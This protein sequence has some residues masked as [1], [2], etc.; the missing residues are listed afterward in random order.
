M[1]PRCTYWSL[2]PNL[3]LKRTYPG[4][5]AARQT[6]VQAARAMMNKRRRPSGAKES[7]M[8][9][10]MLRVAVHGVATVANFL[11]YPQNYLPTAAEALSPMCLTLKCSTYRTSSRYHNRGY[12]GCLD[13]C[14]YA[15]SA[16]FTTVQVGMANKKYGHAKPIVSFS[17]TGSTRPLQPTPPRT[18]PYPLSLSPPPPRKTP[19]KD[20]GY[21][22]S[23]AP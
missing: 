22:R 7:R 1:R 10:R 4:K 20:R 17:C 23:R 19:Q 16:C 21:T 8:G 5:L 18:P 11:P 12:A 14:L 6:S 13:G 2:M 3:S 15:P 9:A